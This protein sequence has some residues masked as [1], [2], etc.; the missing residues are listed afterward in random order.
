MSIETNLYTTLSNDA[1]VTAL[2]GTRIY[3][4]PA[5]EGAEKPLISY[6]VVAGSRFQTIPGV[7]D[8]TRKRIQINC[9][10]NTYSS[11]KAVAAA[12][13]SAL[14]GDGYLDLEFDIYDP[15]TQTHTVA[16]DWSFI[17]V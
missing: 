12:V 11:A 5:P 3:P 8:A 17:A 1:G 16:V 6:F 4:N 7:G 13:I 15:D 14:E 10:A 2:V 9:H